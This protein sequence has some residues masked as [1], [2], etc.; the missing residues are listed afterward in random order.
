MKAK[1]VKLSKLAE[2]VGGELFG[3][4]HLEICGV[5]D[6][7]SAG[8]G[9]ISFLADAKKV[10]T[11]ERSLASAVIIPATLDHVSK[12]AIK[13]RD[14]YLAIAHIHNFF[15]EKPFVATGIDERAVIGK[16]CR[17]S[18]DISIGPLVVIGDRVQIGRR[19]RLYPG[20]VVGDDAVLGDD[21]TLHPNVAVGERCT[22]GNRV[23]IHSGTVVG[24]D[25][26]GYATDENGHHVKRP[27]VGIVQIDDDVEIGANVCID[28]ATFGKTWVQ[29]GVKI[30]NL[31][32]LAH[33][34]VVGEDSFLVAQVGIAGS[35]TTGRSVILG[36]QVGVAGHIHLG[37]RVMVAAMS[38][39][40]NNLD[41]RLV[42]AG[43]PAIPHPKWLRASAVYAKLPEL[44]KELREVKKQL[45]EMKKQSGGSEE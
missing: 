17:I 8:A 20:V 45:A 15:I 33:N 16:D 5:A 24:S 14:P 1:V 22:L 4:P 38:G 7:S 42:V 41:D 26:F 18:E 28:R 30:D 13:V 34:V 19:V 27:Q 21:V 2:M 9:D 31:V 10:S 40:H 37:D 6:L 12:P 11:L 23:T 43:V 36:G 29:R 3:D 39:V 35:T 44:V 32:Q 25:G